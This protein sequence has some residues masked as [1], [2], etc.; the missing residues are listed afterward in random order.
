MILPWQKPAWQRGNPED[1]SDRGRENAKIA[2]LFSCVL[3]RS[4]A[5][6]LPR[7]DNALAPGF[8]QEY[9]P[10]NKKFLASSF[11]R[12]GFYLFFFKTP[13]FLK[14]SWTKNFSIWAAAWI[15]AGGE[16]AGLDI[17]AFVL[18]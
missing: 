15:T 10:K 16:Q 12:G 5:A 2:T 1:T 8:E 3:L 14:E 11:Q 9:R 6:E 4:P 17:F 7:N 13:T 18:Y